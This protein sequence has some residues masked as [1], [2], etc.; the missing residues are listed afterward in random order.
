MISIALGHASELE[1]KI[2]LP[3]TPYMNHRLWIS[4]TG[5]LLEASSLL[6]SLHSAGKF[7][8]C[9]EKTK[10]NY[11][12]QPSVN[13]ENYNNDLPGKKGPLVQ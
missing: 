12:F 2:Q 13:A 9:Y 5:I 11:Q 1:G 8:A 6:D 3:K 10:S 4:L 7:Y